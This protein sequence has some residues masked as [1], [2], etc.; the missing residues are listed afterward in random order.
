MPIIWMQLYGR[1]RIG[2]RKKVKTGGTTSGFVMDATN[3]PTN[4][5]CKLIS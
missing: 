5:A 1:S 3:K 4:Y 2:Q